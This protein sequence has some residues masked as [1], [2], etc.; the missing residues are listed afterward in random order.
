MIAPSLALLLHADRGREGEGAEP[1]WRRLYRRSENFSKV[2]INPGSAPGWYRYS[3]ARCSNV[4]VK[5]YRFDLT[6]IS[7]V[8]SGNHIPGGWVPIARPAPSNCSR[9]ARLPAGSINVCLAVRINRPDLNA[10]SLA[11]ESLLH[12]A[13]RP[14]LRG[15]RCIQ[16]IS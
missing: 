3:F 12:R 7:S 15:A 16:A 5:S 1:S 10:A 13:K 9:T 6:E 4:R 2:S 11:F 14:G 8:T